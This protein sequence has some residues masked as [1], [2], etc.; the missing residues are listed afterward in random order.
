[1]S[2]KN[3]KVPDLTHDIEMQLYAV[4]THIEGV[5]YVGCRAKGVYKGCPIECTSYVPASNLREETMDYVETIAKNKY[6][7][8]CR[9]ID[10]IEKPRPRYNEYK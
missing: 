2:K 10:G 1:M 4:E 6:R 8:E 5:H 3:N 9:V 7:H